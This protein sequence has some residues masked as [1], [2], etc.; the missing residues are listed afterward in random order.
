[1]V[2]LT[3][4]TSRLL[5]TIQD[6]RPNVMNESAGHSEFQI[7]NFIINAQPTPY[8]K[9]RQCVAELRSRIKTIEHA[10]NKKTE[11]DTLPECH[12][13]DA[14][15]MSESDRLR[16]Q[17]E[18]DILIEDLGRE[19]YIFR[20]VF[21]ELENQVD[22]SRRDELEAEF[23]SKKFESDLIAHWMSGAP[24][25]PSLVQNIML[26]PDGAPAKQKLFKFL[27]CRLE[28]SMKKRLVD[29]EFKQLAEDQSVGDD[30]AKTD[31]DDVTCG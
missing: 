16:K 26:L 19:I 30:A 20:D 5:E 14:S 24:L 25:P 9:Y 23:W 12:P 11:L 3:K 4:E 1:M 6:L 15:Q 8:G 7:R 17:V 22:L 10:I 2:T 13:Q 31:Q 27:S 28:G 18:L 29:T 21:C